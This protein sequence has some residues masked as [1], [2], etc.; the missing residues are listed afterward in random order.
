MSLL[1]FFDNKKNPSQKEGKSLLCTSLL[2]AIN[3]AG[4]KATCA[5]VNFFNAT[6]WCIDFDFLD[7]WCPTTS[8]L[9]VGVADCVAAHSTFSTYTAYS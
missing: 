9:S 8:C 5:N 2:C 3:F 6:R 7:V 1:N 4:T